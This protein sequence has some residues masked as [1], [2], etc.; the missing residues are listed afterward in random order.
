M[1]LSKESILELINGD[2]P[3]IEDITD[4]SEQLQPNSFDMSVKSI[5]RF[6]NSGKLGFYNVDRTLP[7][8]KELKPS[9][10][11][12]FSSKQYYRLKKGCY[13]VKLKEKVNLPKDVMALTKPRS[14]LMRSGCDINSAVWD[15]G[16]SG[17]GS[18]LLD[19]KN[20]DGFKMGLNARICQMIFIKLT[21]ETEGYKG[22]YQNER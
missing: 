11:S 4:L 16:Y 18:V 14:S 1:I 2:M 22:I 8:M 9:V 17:N 15:A 7:D 6:K 20:D 19:V 13:I 5:Y 21:G 10:W 12:M 3:L